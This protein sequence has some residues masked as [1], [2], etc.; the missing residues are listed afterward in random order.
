MSSEDT[1]SPA[2]AGYTINLVNPEYIGYQSVITSIVSAGLSAFS[3]ACGCTPENSLLG[4]WDGV[5][6]GLF[7]PEYVLLL[8]ALSRLDM[9]DLLKNSLASTLRLTYFAAS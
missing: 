7:A 1:V 2:P 8:R 9:E 4:I 3:L 5:T 6:D